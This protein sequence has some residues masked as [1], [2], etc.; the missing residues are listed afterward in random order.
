MTTTT[1]KARATYRFIRKAS[2]IDPKKFDER[3]RSAIHEISDGEDYTPD[4][5]IQA[6]QWVVAGER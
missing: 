2:G 3:A 4:M 6:A 5:W 1:E